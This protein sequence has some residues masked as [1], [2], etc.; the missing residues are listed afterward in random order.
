MDASDLD[1][2][3]CRGFHGVI[4][5]ANRQE[6]DLPSGRTALHFAVISRRSDLACALLF[7]GVEIEARDCFGRTPLDLERGSCRG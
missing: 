5:E 7:E 1:T 3:V 4:N 6:F 2:H